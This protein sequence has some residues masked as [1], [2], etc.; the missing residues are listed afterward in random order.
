MPTSLAGRD[1][2]THPHAVTEQAKTQ[3]LDILH[4]LVEHLFCL[5]DENKSEIIMMLYFKWKLSSYS[6]LLG[7]NSNWLIQ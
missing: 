3:K 1:G 6:Y 4:D 2:S 7:K 5:F